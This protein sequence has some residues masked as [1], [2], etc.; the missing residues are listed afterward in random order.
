MFRPLTGEDEPIVW[1]MLMYASHEITLNSV[2]SQPYL[3]R[4]AAA[5]GRAGDTGFVAIID[6]NQSVGAAWL[7]LWTEDNRGFGYVDDATPELAM[8]VLPEYRGQHIGTQLLFYLLKAVQ[9]IYPAVSLNVRAD[10]SVVRLY[11]RVGFVKIE[12]S[13]IINRTDG[14]SF[15]MINRLSS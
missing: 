4:Y 9:G 14:I 3:A 5:W 1:Q 15:N 6:N 2:K 10:N 12:G 8:A 13:E 11:Q 7:R